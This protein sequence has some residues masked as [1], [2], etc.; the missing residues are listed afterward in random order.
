MNDERRPV[1]TPLA[2]FREA[3]V[4]T[5]RDEAPQYRLVRLDLRTLSF[6]R[7]EYVAVFDDG[8]T[9]PVTVLVGS[10]SSW[11]EATQF[12]HLLSD[13]GETLGDPTLDASVRRRASEE[14]VRL[15]A[16][17]REARCAA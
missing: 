1:E 16:T 4:P 5:A 17:V 10:G 7:V 14:L 11:F 13:A 8:A 6:E 12:P 15:E 9:R 3:S 2:S